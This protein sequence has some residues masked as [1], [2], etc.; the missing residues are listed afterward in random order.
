MRIVQGTAITYRLTDRRVRMF[1]NENESCII[2]LPQTD[3]EDESCIELV[4]LNV[5]RKEVQL[6]DAS[7]R[8]LKEQ[9]QQ[10]E[11][12]KK[13]NAEKEYK[14]KLE[15]Y[16]SQTKQSRPS[17][18]EN[19]ELAVVKYV[20]SIRNC[21]PGMISEHPV[22]DILRIENTQ[23]ADDL[24]EIIPI[25]NE[26]VSSSEIIRVDEPPICKPMI[27]HL[28]E[29]DFD[30]QEDEEYQTEDVHMD[31]VGNGT[32]DDELEV[33]E[34]EEDHETEN[35]A[36]VF[37]DETE[38]NDSFIGLDG[39]A[40]SEGQRISDRN[41]SLS[42][43]ELT[44][45][46]PKFYNSINSRHVLL[47]LR[48]IIYVHGNLHVK[49]VAGNAQIFGYKLKVNETVTVHSTRGHALIYFTPVEKQRTN[50]NEMSNFNALHELKN[51]FLSQDI[52]TVIQ[53]FNENT[54][55][56]L[57]LERD[58][59]NKGIVMIDRYMRETFFPN[60]NAFKN[61]NP[62]YASEFILHAQFS[63]RPRTGLQL[64][65]NWST[66]QLNR[67]SRLTAIGGKGVGKSTFVRYTI[68]SNLEKFDQF[69]FIDL[70]IGQPE[71]FA[72]Q[73]ISAT[74]LTEPIIGPGYLKNIPPTKA[75]YFGEINVLLNP[76]KYLQCVIELHRFCSASNEFKNMPWIINTMG[77]TRGFGLEL[78]ACI[79]RIFS[80]TDVVQ[81]QSDL[82]NDNFDLIM[83]DKAINSFNFKIFNDEMNEFVSNS[84]FKTHVF[85]AIAPQQRSADLL[86]KD[87]RYAMVLS[88]LGGCL[89]NNFDWL[90]SVK[91]IE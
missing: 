63:F 81:I 47:L 1:E 5:T 69:L 7:R 45:T 56:I 35:V 19:R 51:D 33:V 50:C 21:Q 24:D 13:E 38:T 6:K 74:V 15:K 65:D 17:R 3:S 29:D 85:S 73:T 79:L 43:S 23:Q 61:D 72:P 18:D 8:L 64:S 84:K 41:M 67:N 39:T 68:N 77:Y 88:K 53:E 25:T 86:P 76:I 40:M 4:S 42:K 62:N 57:L 2:E 82:P 34:E 9:Q 10:A 27:I 70:D 75:L 87:I 78:M 91:P 80:P 28:S 12:L 58:N 32:A 31:E 22:A 30:M 59:Q 89:R 54:D 26:D 46:K 14:E 90:T 66:I 71:L 37:D 60:I 48:N 44:K 52:D 36:N 16:Y 20:P 83:R 49:L 11:K 55:A